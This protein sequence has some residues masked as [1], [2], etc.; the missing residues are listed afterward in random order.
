M[1]WVG[2][3]LRAERSNP[4]WVAGVSGIANDQIALALAGFATGWLRGLWHLTT[5]KEFW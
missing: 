4:G 3:S 5:A 1:T 2:V